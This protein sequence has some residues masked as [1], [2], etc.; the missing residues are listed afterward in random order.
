MPF[1]TH[2]QT[3]L[4]WLTSPL[5]GGIGHGFSTRQ[6][7]VSAAPWDSLNLGVGRGDDPAAVVENYRRF[8]GAAGMDENRVVLSKQVHETTVR[9][10]TAADAGKG[11]WS[12]R[13]YTAD[14]LVTNQP[15]LPLVVFSADCGIILLYDP[16]QQAV[17]A[18]HAG[19]RGCAAG[20]VEK[21]VR[22]MTEVFASDP[23]HILAA[24]GPCIGQCC[25]ETDGDVP[26]AMEAALG[27]D[28]APYMERR[29]PK[30][31]VDLAGLNRQ[32]LLR[33]GLTLGH[34][35]TCG[36]CTACH[37]DLFWSHRKMGEARGAQVAMIALS[38]EG[39]L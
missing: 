22:T 27:D 15:D 17:S 14:A 26:A 4:I 39:S 9:V 1:E 35:D 19:W 38:K 20:I 30:W 3:G 28:A 21:T 25:F 24:I 29:G 34:I 8:C 36:L 32:W 7:G 2:E 18:V 6:G 33:S 37:P 23:S 13:D 5:L 31:H 12:S 16:I 10:C 11:L